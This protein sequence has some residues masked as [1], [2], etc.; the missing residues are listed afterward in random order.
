MT[1]AK[2]NE[3][4][5]IGIDFGT[6]SVRAIVVN[7]HNGEVL[8]SSEFEYP[9]WKRGEFCNP[10]KNQFRQHPLDYI[11]GLEATVTMALATLSPDQKKCIRSISADTTGSTPIAVDRNG[12]PLSLLPDFKD[13]PIALFF[14]WKDHSAIKEAEEINHHSKNFDVDYLK[15]VGGIYSSE[16]FWAKLLFALREDETIR[17][18]CYGWVEHCDWIPFLLTGG[19]ELRQMKLGVCAAGHKALWSEDW[20]GFP[21]NDFF[22]SL[23]PLLDGFINRQPNKTYTANHHAGYLS[24]AWAKKFGLSTNILVGVGALDAHVGA[25]GSQIKPNYM[26]KVM[27]TSTCDMLVT[28]FNQMSQKLIQGIC[29]QVNG[30]IIPGMVGMEAGQSAFGD[31]FAWFKELVAWPITNRLNMKGVESRE[32]EILEQLEAGI[33]TNLSEE[34]SKIAPHIEMEYAIEWLNGRRSPDADQHLKGVLNQISLSTDAPKIFRSLVEATC[35][36]AKKIMERFQEHGVRV[37]GIIAIGGVANK[38]SFI[39]QMMADILQVPIKIHR[40]EQTCAHGAAML[41]ATVAGIYTKV[42]DA[43]D[44][45]GAGFKKQYIPNEEIGLI[46]LERYKN[47]GMFCQQQEFSQN[48]LPASNLKYQADL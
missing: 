30:S 1:S 47:Y 28:P 15:Y 17:K 37:D 10:S 34:A 7:A 13:N 35:F 2:I 22:V 32:K 4:L 33:L 36:G 45:M 8:S 9:R 21:P 44:A 20:G 42:E 46:Y 29:G 40:S 5:V 19:T 18:A 14:L 12:T 31:V 3:D 24:A 41:A 23:D 38:S 25:I 48:R 43:M 26:C 16:W 6:A 11:E 39:M 27:G